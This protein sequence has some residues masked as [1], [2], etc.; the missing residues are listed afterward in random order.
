MSRFQ[1]EEIAKRK[2]ERQER[3]EI[4]IERAKEFMI[5]NPTASRSRVATYAGVAV[6]ILESWG[7]VLPKPLTAESK[8]MKTSWA[9]G[10]M[11]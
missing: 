4:A 11:L 8:R 1:V 10:H 2:R 5:K 7:L 3:K 9:K 6:V